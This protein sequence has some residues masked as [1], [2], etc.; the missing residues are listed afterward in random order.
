[1]TE[2]RAVITGLGL[3]T[4]LAA[5]VEASWR[6]LL[7]GESGA[8]VIERFDASDLACR[9]ACEVPY[10]DADDD[11]FD[12]ARVL[13]PRGQRR[14]D[15]FI[16]YALAAAD[17]AVAH[18][19]LA[20][21]D[22]DERTRIGVLVGS[23]IGGLPRIEENILTLSARGP[24]SVSPFF[25]PASLINLASGNIAMRHGF[26]GPNHGVVT[27]CSS[28][29][30]AIGDAAEIVRRGA[31]DAMV[32][33]GAEAAICRIGIAG[34]AACRALS[35]G[36]NDEPTRASRPW[37]RRRDGFVMGEG[38]GIVIVEELERA[39]ARGAPVLAEIRGYGMSGD[40][41][42][43]TAPSPD[44][45]GARRSMEAAL[46]SA[47]IAPA[48]IDYVNAHGTSTPAGDEIEIAA[49]KAAFGGAVSHLAVSSTK[50]SVGHLLGAA[51]AVEAV[52][53]VLALRD[54]V[55]PPTLNLEDPEEDWGIDLVPF[56]AQRRPVRAAL[57]NSFGF[58]GTNASLV[59]TA[60]PD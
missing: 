2:R 21:E 31:A 25:I 20:T 4:P 14:I 57:S 3:V 12:P 42:H 23:G 18:A 33:G 29:A 43:V 9:V 32:A 36:F 47:G 51:G 53:A 58:G 15:T 1:M 44:G 6:R 60:P 13:P 8:G 49:M 27:A 16:L 50:S 59:L 37:D 54:G 35:T 7:R 46:A 55:V 22:P 38:A 40:A 45:D 56:E 28:G 41:H 39:R 26:R 19:G 30:H 11:R 52:F 5:G 24:R 34:F 17:E 48:A 10:G